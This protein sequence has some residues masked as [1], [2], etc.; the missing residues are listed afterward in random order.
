M[1][2]WYN[3]QMHGIKFFIISTYIFYISAVIGVAFINPSWYR[4]LDYIVKIY[5]GFFLVY[6]FNPF[7][8]HVKF[9]ELD[10]QISFHAGVFILSIVV[11]NGIFASYVPSVIKT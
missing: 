2:L 7:R 11:V 5:V 10:R 4:M 9:T 3:L 8:S 1:S 6:R